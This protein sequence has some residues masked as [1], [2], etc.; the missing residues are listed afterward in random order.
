MHIGES[1]E[2]KWKTMKTRA[3]VLC[4]LLAVLLTVG[5][6]ACGG[7]AEPAA[8]SNAE[9][10]AETNAPMEAAPTP[11]PTPEPTQEPTE[12]PTPEPTEEPT[13]TPEPPLAIEETVLCD[14]DEIRI[15]AT[16]IESD[17]WSI[18]LLCTVENKTDTDFDEQP[19]NAFVNG[20]Q[21]SLW[22]G[23]QSVPAHES[24][25]LSLTLFLEDLKPMMITENTIEE[26]KI[27][28]EYGAHDR[29]W[30]WKEAGM[31]P[32]KTN[33]TAGEPFDTSAGTVLY[34]GNGVKMVFM[35]RS[36][37]KKELVLYIENN[38]DEVFY[39][40]A[41]GKKMKID[42]YGTSDWPSSVHANAKKLTS[43]SYY[44]R[45]GSLIPIDWEIKEVTFAYGLEIKG[46][47][48]KTEPMTFTFE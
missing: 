7:A 13:P 6:L 36:E 21:C 31:T 20:F 23:I 44:D 15:V 9:A 47:K 43:E 24:I 5:S 19:S 22:S 46:K 3:I 41:D 25:D 8:P 45:D 39:F 18:S 33:K 29:Y 28:F 17:G 26:I 10:Q 48:Y 37:D 40:T 34:E 11:A 4:L 1:I 38:T 2:R 32:I 27:R 16:G 35:G 30:T 42:G 12:E 14:N